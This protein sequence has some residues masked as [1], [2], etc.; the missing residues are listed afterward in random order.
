MS[1]FKKD[2]WIRKIIFS[3]FFFFVWLFLF[4][5]QTNVYLG[6]KSF[7]IEHINFCIIRYDKHTWYAILYI[8]LGFFIIM[9]K[10]KKKKIDKLV[11]RGCDEM[12][13]KFICVKCHKNFMLILTYF[14]SLKLYWSFMSL[15]SYIVNQFL[16]WLISKVETKMVCVCD[17]AL[18]KTEKY[19]SYW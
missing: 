2:S 6:N 15:I 18:L 19:P 17:E 8:G 14:S 9:L 7:F 4:N 16:A 10:W 13:I 1:F 5:I 12:Y 3:P 11:M